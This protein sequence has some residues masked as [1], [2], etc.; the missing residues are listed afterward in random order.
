MFILPPAFHFLEFQ[1]D[2]YTGRVADARNEA[3][4]IHCERELSRLKQSLPTI[5][6]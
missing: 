1:I 2:H 3:E 6:N 4:R 5:Y